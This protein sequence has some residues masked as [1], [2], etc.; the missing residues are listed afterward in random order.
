MTASIDMSWQI[1]NQGWSKAESL[2]SELQDRLDDA[3][4]AMSGSIS[5]PYPSVT[6]ISAITKP[7]VTIPMEAQGPDLTL[8]NQYNDDIINKLAGLFSSYLSD[9][10]PLS[11]TTVSLAEQWV[12]GQI[13]NGGSGINAAVEAQIVE[14]DRSRILADA[15]RAEE[16]VTDL[17]AARRFPMPAGA[18]AYQTLTIQQKAQDEIAKS[19]REMAIKAW[20]SELEMVK[21]SIDEALKLRS[22]AIN[23]AGDYIKSMAASQNTSFQLAMGKSQAQNALISAA[24]N[25][26]NAETNAQDT[27]FKS[28]Y[29]NKSIERDAGLKMAEISKDL[30]VERGKVA[31][32]GADA[33]ARQAQAALNNLH[34]SVGVQGTEKIA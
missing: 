1:I 11:Q 8:F 14:R 33:V 23:A 28:R 24:A 2:N 10:F 21:L 18:L 32:Q 25:W 26:Y 17:W 19:S 13:T 34:T 5:V 27:M 12:Q 4:T 15:V 20:E 6:E 7:S 29:S 16:E 30:L 3:R 9:Y 22:L 31:I